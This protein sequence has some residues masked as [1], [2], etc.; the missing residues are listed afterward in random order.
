MSVPSASRVIFLFGATGN[1]GIPLTQLLSSTFSS[2]GCRIRCQTRDIQSAHSQ[3]LAKL[4]H[5][6]ML[7]TDYSS[8]GGVLAAMQDVTRVY[9]VNNAFDMSGVDHM[10]KWLQLGKGQLEF[11]TYMTAIA[12]GEI[13]YSPVHT[14]GEA[15]IRASGIPYCFLRPIR[16]MQ[17]FTNPLFR[18]FGINKGHIMAADGD[19]PWAAVDCR[20]IAECAATILSAPT[21]QLAKYNGQA[22]S[23]TGS[24]LTTG[25]QQAAIF[26]Q[27][28]GTPIVFD[29]LSMDGYKAF[30]EQLGF[31]PVF[32]QGLMRGTE[33]MRT[34]R[35]AIVA[36]GVR[37]ILGRDPRGWKEFLAD[38]GKE[39]PID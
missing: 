32:V 29:N 16:F 38:H 2:H 39:I 15:A 7:N 14:A 9:F 4:P 23:L 26:T 22:Y 30:L 1:V 34:G 28:F 11:V 21:H 3:Q 19:I 6:E 27:Y 24:E 8:D 35:A 12:T 36:P 18:P 13:D 20:D 31:P 25:D 37:D 10:K 33:Y 5:V 17:N